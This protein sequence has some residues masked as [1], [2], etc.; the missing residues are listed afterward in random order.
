[1]ASLAAFATTLLTIGRTRLELLAVELEEGRSHLL[2]LI[3]LALITL[4][5]VGVGLVLVSLLVLVVFWDQH[6]VLA[7]GLL[8][9]GYLFAGLIVGAYA[10]RRARATPK[11]FAA[12]LA[13]LSADRAELARHS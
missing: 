3:L 5:C 10:V 13:A 6:R 4:F 9:G 11:L 12:S 7:L 1:M 2:S 8:G